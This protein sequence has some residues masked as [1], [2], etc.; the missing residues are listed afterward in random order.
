[1]HILCSYKYTPCELVCLALQAGRTCSSFLFSN[2]AMTTSYSISTPQLLLLGP[3]PAKGWAKGP[4]PVFGVGRGVCRPCRAVSSALAAR[5]YWS[6]GL[7]VAL[8]YCIAALVRLE[9]GPCRRS[10]GSDSWGPS[11]APPRCFPHCWGLLAPTPINHC[12]GSNQP[13]LGVVNGEGV[14]AAPQTQEGR[15][16]GAL[17]RSWG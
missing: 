12:G 14:G 10:R 2:M 5:K 4:L 17:A 8:Q 16:Q 7:P 11:V 9:I 6:L 3:L 1:M 15:G 13:G